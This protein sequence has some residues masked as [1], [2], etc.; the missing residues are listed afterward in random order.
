MLAI[1][2]KNMGEMTK[3]MGMP[4]LI[5]IKNGGKVLTK[6]GYRVKKM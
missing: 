4:K 2:T 1:K 6:M 3:N 5:I